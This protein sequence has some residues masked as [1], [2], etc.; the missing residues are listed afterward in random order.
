[1]S[2]ARGA[3]QRGA[4]VREG[5]RVTDV[6]VSGGRVTGVQTDQGDIEAEVV[7]N[8]AGMW[9]RE[10][11]QLSGVQVPLQALA[12]YY[13]VTDA[14]PGLQRNLP[15]IKSADD[16]SYVKDEAGAL[17]VGF[18]E[19]G[20]YPWASKGIPRNE[21]FVRLPEDW[22]HLGPFYERM[23]ERIPILADA[24]IRLHFSGPE[25]FTPDGFYHLGPAPRL[26]NY[27]LAAGFNS[28]GFLTGPG[29]GAT[30]AD[31]IVDGRPP[32]VMP[33]VDPARVQPH[34]TN[35]R[36]LEARVLETLDRSYGLHWPFEQR[37]SARPLRVSPLYEKTKEQGA[38]FGQLLG[39]ERPNWYATGAA[40]SDYEYSFGRPNWFEA[41]GQ[42]HRAVREAVGMF[43]TSSFGK[44]LVQGRDALAVLQRLSI[45]QID[46]AVGRVV[47]TQWL[48]EFAGIEADVTVTRLGE[49][50]FLVLSGPGTVLRDLARLRGAVGHDENCTVADI[51]GSMA[52]IAVMGP[53]SRDLLQS[54]T[55]ADLS[56]E[57][58]P[59]ATSREIDLGLGFVRA[60]RLTFVGELG[61]ELLI[62]TDL[63]RHIHDVVR[64]VG[65]PYGLRPA[66]Y[67]AMNSLRLEKAYRSWGHDIASSDNPVGA[68]LDF[69]I[70]WDKPGGFIGREAL[71]GIKESGVDR[72]LMQFV[73]ADPEPML[74]H[75]EPVYR[76]GALV[77]RVEAAQYGYTLGGAV[78]LG[79][80]HAPG[81]EG[82]DWF[83]QGSYEIQIPGGRIAAT[84]SLRPQYDPSSS[85]IRC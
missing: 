52:M 79:W 57:A 42:E 69:G 75:D 73:L 13:I 55:D 38:V 80:V 11:G 26:P 74:F 29:A 78:A 16:C 67:Y 19:P 24:G 31:W 65:E 83:E 30:L 20:S 76:D 70:A 58:F 54:L 51:T 37:T 22:D 53:R 46:V 21:G 9:G 6:Y 40:D 36:F 27:F 34:E 85:R 62:P 72:R 49:S 7:V 63:A 59:F 43:D 61:W 23:I 82:G 4:M 44:L 10:L 84:A 68:G 3:T 66:G 32:V 14:I 5:V 81:I 60:T 8:A 12:H 77:G 41:S 47:Y 28:T 15:T 50:E 39:W 48:N 2:L 25:A 45:R 33:E 18:F 17:M 1:M 64:G 35:R 56:H 71:A